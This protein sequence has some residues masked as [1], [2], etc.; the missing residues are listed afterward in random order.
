MPCV[1]VCRRYSHHAGELED[2]KK[3]KIILDQFSA[4][5]GL[6]IN[7]HKSSTMPLHM[8]EELIPK[9]ID[10]LGYRREGF[11]QTYLGLALSYYD[12]LMLSALGPY[13][14]KTDRYL[15]G[16]QASFLNL[17]REYY[18]GQ[19]CLDGQLSYI[20]GAVSLPP[21]VIARIDKR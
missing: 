6:L 19:C 11:P 5:T 18:P 3:L 21:G 9:C 15:A 14:C 1:A 16:R 17:M 7:Y 12:K 13:I 4:A 2:V 20:M 8:K 10:V